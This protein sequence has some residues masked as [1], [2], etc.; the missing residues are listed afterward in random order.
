MQS[1]WLDN[2]GWDDPLKPLSLL[3]WKTFIANQYGVDEIRIPR[4]VKYS[5]NCKIQVHGFC[6]SS[7]LAY[8]AAMYLRVEVGENI[9]TNLLVS[10]SKVA[11]IKKVSLPRLELCGA[12]LLAELADSVLPQ[13]KF[14]NSILVPWSDSMI[15]LAW[16]RKP[17]YTW[18]TF[19][20]NRV[21]IIQEKVGGNWR[22][23]PTIENPADLATRGVTPL[24]LKASTLWW[25]GPPW[26]KGPE[27]YWPVN[28][29]L[30][31]TSLES[32]P[33]KT[34]I[35]RST[36]EEDFLSRFSSLSRAVH[37]TAYIFRFFRKTHP[38]TKKSV[39]F[40]S[41]RLTAAELTFVR[42]RLMSLS[43]RMHFAREYACLSRMKKLE[44]NSSIL[45]LTPFLDK[46][47]LIRANGRLG[48]TSSLTY[49]ERHPVI[50]AYQSSFAK[51]YV[52][53]IHKLTQHGSVQLTLATTRLECW[54]LRAKSL[55]KHHIHHCKECVIARKKRLGQ[56]MG[57]LPSERTT[58][59]RPF[60]NTGVDYAG[61]FDLKNFTGR[62]SRISKGYICLFV[63]FSTKAVHLEPVSD[64]SSSAFLAALTRFVARRGCPHRIY[65]DN[66]RNFVGAAKEL[67]RDFM[68]TISQLKDDAI[69]KYGYQKLEWH[70]IPAASP[71][72]GGLWE[73]G[74]KSCKTHLKKMSGQIRHTFEEFATILASIESCM[75]S[76]PLAA[77]SDSDNDITALTPGHFLIGSSLLSPPEPEN[78]SQKISLLNRWNRLKIIQLEF[79]RRWKSEYLKEMTKRSKW[80]DSQRDLQVDDLVVLR[81]ESLCPNEWRLGR[82]IKLY[83]GNDGRVRVVDLKTQAGVLTRSVHKLV[84]LPN[85]DQ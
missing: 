57:V 1:L 85:S 75:N 8:A 12:L 76:R 45:S 11:P 28:K 63:C 82:I 22:H 26:L 3:K 62:G 59:S 36:I 84:L 40:E 7:E 47:S 44:S 43:Q 80:T 34:H 32:K 13:L 81:N 38:I 27:S 37:V 68:K 33:L 23:V 35:A 24:E 65:S 60:T 77:L 14:E 41:K 64:L 6:D 51:L 50:L 55:I 30:P 61:P 79:C 54:I 4:W 42:Y 16:L 15:V 10:K 39:C 78:A 19:V 83:H 29:L 46:D 18:T 66:G 48:S 69:A 52:A 74:I 53:F 5:P 25:E 17:S 9:Y 21:A 71:H 72:M 67:R 70:F 31:E 58:F 20:A 49:S 56:L 73:A 2:I